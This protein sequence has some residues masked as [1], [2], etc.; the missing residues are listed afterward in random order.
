MVTRAK[1]M[2]AAVAA[3][4]AAALAGCGG[5]SDGGGEVAGASC[6]S[7]VVWNGETYA[8][9]DTRTVYPPAGAALTPKGTDPGCYGP[10]EGPH[11]ATVLAMRGVPPALGVRVQ[12]KDY[13]Y[14]PSGYFIGL[15]DHPLHRA[16][17]GPGEHPYTPGDGRRCAVVG[18]VIALDATSV[19]VRAAS[20][21]VAM[22]RVDVKTRIDGFRRAGQPHLRL[23]DRVAIHG[24]RCGGD[25]R[26]GM[27]AVTIRPSRA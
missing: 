5:E 8:V 4:A 9:R 21:R 23:G 2:G 22:A 20:G 12:G 15:R 26:L 17:Y 27:T 24:R 3:L 25:A 1:A 13:A 16:L 14:L 6:S 11:P 10:G 18:P 19:T 7:A